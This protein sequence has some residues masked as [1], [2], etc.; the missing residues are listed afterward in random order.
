[1]DGALYFVIFPLKS[2]GFFLVVNLCKEKNKPKKPL[3]N[4]FKLYKNLRI[5]LG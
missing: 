5:V 4:S 3:L 2:V 1:M